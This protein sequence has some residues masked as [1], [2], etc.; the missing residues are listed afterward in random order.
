MWLP[1]P[2]FAGFMTRDTSSAR[3]A[4][5][6]SRPAGDTARDTLDWLNASNGPVVGLTAE[7][8]KDVLAAW[9]AHQP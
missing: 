9:H 4:G 8:E 2:D 6:T 3:E 5:L 1:L 7:D